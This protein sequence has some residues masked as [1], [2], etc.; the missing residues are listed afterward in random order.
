MS[1]LKDRPQ[2]PWEGGGIFSHF[3]SHIQPVSFIYQLD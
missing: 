2:Q 3:S 1:G